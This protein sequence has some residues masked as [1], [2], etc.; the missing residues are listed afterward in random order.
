MKNI[1][2]RTSCKEGIGIDGK[3]N[4]TKSSLFGQTYEKVS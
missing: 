2:R 3:K 1:V 4:F